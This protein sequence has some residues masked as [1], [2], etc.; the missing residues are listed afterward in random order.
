MSVTSISVQEN[1]AGR[2]AVTVGVLLD[3]AV[4]EEWVLEALRQAMAVPGVVLGAVALVRTRGPTGVSARLHRFVERMDRRLR[5]DGDRMFDRVDV[6][7]ALGRHRPLDIALLRDGDE[8]LV[9]PTGASALRDVHADV[10]LCFCA[11][12]PQ[13]PFPSVSRLGVWGLEIGAHVPAGSAWAG[14]SEVGA[15]SD[16]TVAQVVDY[17]QPGRNAVYRACGATIKNSAGRNRQVVLHKA[18]T[19]FGRLLRAATSEPGSTRALSAEL[20]PR[21]ATRAPTVRTLARLCTRLAAQVLANRWHALMRRDQW[22]IGYYFADEDTEVAYSAA[23]LRCLVPPKD[24]DW[25]DPFIMRHDGRCFIFFEELLYSAGK[26]HISAMEIYADGEAGAPRPVLVRPYHLSYPFIFS[27]KG[28]FYMLPETAENG[29]VELYRCERFP[30]RWSLHKVLLEGIRAFDATLL[31]EGE[32]WWLFVNV[33]QPGADPNEELHLYG[34]E[35]PLGPWVAHP[36]N[37]VISD[38]RQARGAGPLFWRN[39]QLYRPSQDCSTAY[40]SAVSINRVDV[41]DEHNY[42][43][44]PVGRINPDRQAGMRCLHT[45][46]ASGRLRVLDFMVRRSRWSRT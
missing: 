8:W 26:A 7:A 24:R 19:F 9:S 11:T 22:R 39:G 45:F 43:E 15:S 14:A 31:R 16:V 46:G 23:Q 18:I 4:Q 3:D 2:A 36:G 38:A 44:T 41:L 34:S 35:S 27:W 28:E 40:G 12:A 30:D 42:Q 33:A 37:P 13:C 21:G 20:L 25:A 5:C 29:T 1:A 6:V 32:R 17:T 10:W